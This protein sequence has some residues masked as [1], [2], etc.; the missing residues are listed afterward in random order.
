MRV[1]LASASSRR[2]ELLRSIG[3]EFEIVPADID[4]GWAP[5]EHPVT[6]VERVAAGKAAA[7]AMLLGDP[8]DAVILAADTTVDLD[9][10]ILAKPLDGHDARRMLRRLSGRTHRVHTAVVGRIRHDQHAVTVTTDVTFAELGDDAI[11]WYLS[12]GEHVDKA[13]AYGMQGAGGALVIRIAGSPSNVVGLP[14]VETVSVLRAFGVD[15][16]TP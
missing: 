2:H 7:V 12:V 4:E 13:G 5:A 10:E 16:L 14:L 6:Y 15:P 11:S 3:V 1:I 9:G 8:D